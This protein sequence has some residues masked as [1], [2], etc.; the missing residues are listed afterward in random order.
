MGAKHQLIF[1]DEHA[2]HQMLAP[3]L[4]KLTRPKVRQS[5]SFIQDS[6]ECL[7]RD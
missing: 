1:V 5:L 4:Q 2:R 6:K 7:H 3:H